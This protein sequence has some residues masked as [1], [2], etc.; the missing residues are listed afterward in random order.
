MPRFLHFCTIA[1][2]II[3][4]AV[5]CSPAAAQLEI[6][7]DTPFLW[8]GGD[9]ALAI[10]DFNHDGKM[11]VALVSKE[12]DIFLGKGD[13]TF[14]VPIRI[15]IPGE[16]VLNSITLADFNG[17]GEADIALTG[18]DTHVAGDIHVSVLFGNGDGTFTLSQTL[19][20]QA[21]PNYLNAADLNGDGKPDLVVMT[22]RSLTSFLNNGNG[23]FGAAKAMDFGNNVSLNGM[24][25]GDFNRDG[26]PDV[27]L[28]NSYSN[29]EIAIFLGNGDGTFTETVKYTGVD[30]GS[31]PIAVGD[32]RGIGVLDLAAAPYLN[33]LVEIYL[34]NGDG[35]FQ[36][37]VFYPSDS[38]FSI[39]TADMNG[40]GKLDLV[41][42]NLVNIPGDGDVVLLLG[43][44]DGT[45]QSQEVFFTG[46]LP[47]YVAV[48]DMNGDGKPDVMNMV[49]GG[50]MFTLLNTGTVNFLPTT[51]VTFASQLIGTSSTPM[52]AQMT[53]AGTTPVTI[54]SVTV[55]GAPFKI[56][57]N[58][59]TG[60]LAAGAQ[61]KIS[62]SFAPTA[63]NPVIGTLSIVDNASSK[64][65]VIELSGAGTVVKLVPASLN[66]PPTKVGTT[67][68]PQT[69]QLTNTGSGPLN[70]TYKI[71][72]GGDF[73]GN[74][75]ETNTCPKQLAAGA[76]CTFTVTF[77]P[78]GTGRRDA[79]LELQD[80]GGG[81]P[82]QPQLTGTGD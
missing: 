48:G 16:D 67:S 46:I 30:G 21:Y 12:L 82:Q 15:T 73:Y 9:G 38:G 1:V 41:L 64:P 59:C 17:D 76:S 65:Q 7:T 13:G 6:R 58:A 49:R 39:T 28:S 80:D 55:S 62:T 53:N 47:D 63:E 50:D 19:N 69:M 40:D 29:G 52:V 51:P 77:S 5:F 24:G 32:F 75:T 70:F 25:V 22:D 36:A 33:N 68:A 4:A 81:S 42:D 71:Y 10:G 23:T 37:P 35:T 79:Y 27:A 43:N 26:I 56:T 18:G 11:D 66:F 8:S 72:V 44:G 60:S 61:C 34:G 3:F 74:Y 20:V 78:S 54:S 14:R 31:G 57:H 2:V 45:F